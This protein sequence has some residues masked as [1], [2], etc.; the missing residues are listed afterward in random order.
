MDDERKGKVVYFAHPIAHY[1]TD[2]EWE[3]IETI[4]HMLTP[5]GEDPT[6]GF[7]HIM[8]PNQRWLSNLYIQ[9][10]D[11]GHKDPFDI[12]RQIASA[13]DIIVGVTFMN[14]KIGAGVGEEME[15][16]IKN[17]IPAYLIMLHEAQKLFLPISSMDN[18]VILSRDDTRAKIKRGEM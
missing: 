12:F 2:L 4:I 7:I 9:R 14:G 17:G 15:T 6:D 16:C 1:D 18:F 3:C 8:N 13:C 11:S 5:I 10:R